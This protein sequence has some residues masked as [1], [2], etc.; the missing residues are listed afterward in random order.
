[1]I[2]ALQQS[3]DS[4]NCFKSNHMI[5]SGGISCKREYFSDYLQQTLN[6]MRKE[7]RVKREHI[8][9]DE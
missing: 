1:M 9:T 6:L 8:N 7:F 4:A 5:L 3:N 2:K